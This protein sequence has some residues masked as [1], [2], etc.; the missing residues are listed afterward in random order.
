MVAVTGLLGAASW[1]GT[2]SISRNHDLLEKGTAVLTEMN[3]CAIL[4]RDFG[5][6]GFEIVAGESKNAAEKWAEAYSDLHARLTDLE[7]AD[8]LDAGKLELVHKTQGSVGNY[9]TSFDKVAESRRMR[10]Q[11]REVW[12]TVGMQITGE[13]NTV[14]KD[15]IDPGIQKSKDDKKFEEM[16]KWSAI[17]IGLNRD[18]IQ[19]FL[20]MR[21]YGVYLIALGGDAQWTEL[22][23]QIKAVQ[24]GLGRW[25]ALVK[26]TAQ[27][28]SLAD[29]LSEYIRQYKAA[30]T[31]Y[32]DGLQMERESEAS[33]A[34]AARD[35][36]VGVG[37]L[38][39]QF[40]QEMG[41]VI[42][43]T[44]RAILAAIIGSLAVGALLAVVITRAISRSVRQVADRIK[45][46][47]QGE[48]D[49]T[50]R[51][52]VATKDE[53]GELCHWFNVFVDKLQGI[54]KQIAGNC[55]TLAGAST[56]LSAT[57]T[58]LAGGAEE[59]TNQSATVAAAAEEMSTSM[60]SMAA[61]TEEMSANVKTVAAAVEEMTASI[62][63][64]AKNAEQA[65][66]VADNASQLA[67]ASNAKVTRLGAAAED[68]GKIIL[69]IQDIAEQ[70]NLLALNA[71][72]EAARAG[73]AGKGFAVV[74][75]EVKELAKQTAEATDNIRQS[76][77]SIQGSIGETVESIGEISNVIQEVNSVSRTI[78]SAVEE[79][80]I[81]T[82]EIASNVSQTA[83]AAQNVSQGV[84]Q[85]ASA[86]REITQNI[87]GVDVAAKQTAQGAA[88]TQS[89]GQELSELAEEL[90]TLVGQFKV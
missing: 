50:R 76:I 36:V 67:E 65:A 53:I 52:A 22:E 5:I 6:K 88:H 61:S 40:D 31:T 32:R 48:G 87:A 9:K 83:S 45:D 14:L 16:E 1:W 79:Q 69:T 54:I 59:T 39:R 68:I 47:A 30:A 37:E 72:I 60:N 58:Q 12:R 42:A 19:P 55:V 85:T 41:A 74:A 24:D 75:N 2:N 64:V 43:Q 10:D 13:L 56:E 77:E 35:V 7:Q 89:A 78:A 90:K 18:F 17:S 27:L 26:G 46:I 80:S 21:V 51:L 70:T 8:G 81:T 4:R 25:S 29:K 57:A 34:K 44:R 28:D 63:E 86:S 84:A 66:R 3:R 82:K 23:A 20:L 73:E 62:G 38:D 11:A 49:L 71:T 33:L 15:V